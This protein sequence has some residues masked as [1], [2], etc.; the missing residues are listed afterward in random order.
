MPSTTKRAGAP[1]GPRAC[2]AAA[3]SFRQA[4]R[5]A[6]STMASARYEICRVTGLQAL[7]ADDVAVGDPQRL[8]ALEPPQ[9]PQ[10]RLIVIQGRHLGHDLLDQRLAAPPAAPRSAAAGRSFP[11]RCTNRSLRCWLVA[12]ICSSGGRA[13][14]SRSKSVPD[15]QRIAGGGH[16]AVQVVQR[17]VGIGAAARSW[18]KLVADDRQQVERQARPWP[19]SPGC[20]GPA[21]RRRSPGAQPVRRG[22]GIVEVVGAGWRCSWGRLAD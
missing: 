14:R 17:H 9:R 5:S 15:G 16:E 13:S 20:R 19:C 1:S 3:R 18:R 8:A 21:G 12:K 2:P 11:G 22:V 7:L 6:A 10:H 4:A